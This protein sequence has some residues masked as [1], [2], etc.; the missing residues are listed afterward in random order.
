MVFKMA[1]C[2]W[3]IVGVMA[4]VGRILLKFKMAECWWGVGVMAGVGRILLK[5]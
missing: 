4:G 3:G 5:F 1:E 2:W